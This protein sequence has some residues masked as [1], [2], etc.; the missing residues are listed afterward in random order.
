MLF[1]FSSWL[2]VI[3]NT[4]KLQTLY[5]MLLFMR[6]RR[7]LTEN[8]LNITDDDKWWSGRVVKCKF[9]EKQW[10]IDTILLSPVLNY[11]LDKEHYSQ[12]RSE[13]LQVEL[14]L[15]ELIPLRTEN[16]WRRSQRNHKEVL[17]TERAGTW[18]SQHYLFLKVI[19]VP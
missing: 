5:Y 16:H 7:K 15:I 14:S 4:L 3:W 19:F 1:F 2:K 11:C 13:C 12:E 10:K 9:S 8:N 18:N 17:D 6:V